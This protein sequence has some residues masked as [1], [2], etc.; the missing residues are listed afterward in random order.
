M[1][2][3]IPPRLLYHYIK[4]LTH[5][6]DA[7][8]VKD[9]V[10]FR[11]RMAEA[12]L[13]VAT[14]LFHVNREGAAFDVALR[15]LEPGAAEA[16]IRAH[17]GELFVKP[18]SGIH[19]RDAFVLSPAEC[20]SDFPDTYRNMIV[21]PALKQ[22]SVLAAVYPHA[23]NTIRIDTLRRTAASSTMPL[24]SVWAPE[25]PSWTTARQEACSRASISRRDASTRTHGK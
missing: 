4:S 16:L 3:H 1:E 19:G 7:R 13:P 12:G 11:R 22:H 18:I 6:A 25:V 24:S 10:K 21:Q 14:E 5:E 20:P 2:D 23:I 9:K 8:L 15:P 17:D